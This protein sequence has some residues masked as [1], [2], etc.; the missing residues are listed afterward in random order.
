MKNR[1]A[2]VTGGNKGIGR[3]IVFKLAEQMKYVYFTFNTDL[4]SANEVTKMCSNST[5]IHCNLKD[6]NEIKKVAGYIS[7]K[8]VVVD[9]LINNA[10]Y[11]NDSTFLKMSVESWDEVIDINLKSVFHFT[12]HFL[13]GMISNGWGRII[14]ISSIAASTGAFGKSNYSA[15][16]AGLLGFTKSLALELA[17][18][19]ITV[20]AVSPGAINTN[21][22]NRIPE[23]YR[24]AIIK[25][26]PMKRLGEPIEVANLIKFLVSDESSYITGQNIHVNGG[27]YLE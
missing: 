15:A 9:I 11:D 23:K 3:S 16:K 27:S 21:M 6:I 19:N 5:A 26:I 2:F 13:N 22:F 4:N 1:I 25:N 24:E 17:S 10:G 20:N 8:D 12:K 18:K 7:K 14:N